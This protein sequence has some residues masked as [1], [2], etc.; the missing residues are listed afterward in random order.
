MTTLFHT[1]TELREVRKAAQNRLESH[2]LT[3]KDLSDGQGMEDY[4]TNCWE[5]ID[6]QGRE[7][8]LYL[9]SADRI[10]ARPETKTWLLEVSA[11]FAVPVTF[12]P[13]CGEKLPDIA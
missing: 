12:C 7:Q 9:A 6:P 4:G 8:T 13:C 5:F 11:E 1:C 3:V 2:I 10:I